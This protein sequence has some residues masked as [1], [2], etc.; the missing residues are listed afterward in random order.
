M[1]PQHGASV[2][3]DASH[4]RRRRPAFRASI[5]PY[6]SSDARSA[7]HLDRIA[8]GD[9]FIREAALPQL[10]HSTSHSRTPPPPRKQQRKSAHLYAAAAQSHSSQEQPQK[11]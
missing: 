7:S 3:Q 4:D 11:D 9:R 1:C 2:L 6:S 10:P 5:G 8:A